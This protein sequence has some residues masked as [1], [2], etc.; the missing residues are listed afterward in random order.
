MTKHKI[1]FGILINLLH[2]AGGDW[3][4][5]KLPAS[6]WSTLPDDPEHL[7]KQPVPADR[8]KFELRTHGPTIPQAGRTVLPPS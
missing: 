4:A 8:S 5:W 3:P 6:P 2:G 1:Y 7:V